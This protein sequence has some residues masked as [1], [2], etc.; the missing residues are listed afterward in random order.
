MEMSAAISLSLLSLGHKRKVKCYNGYFVNGYVFH[1]KEYGHGRKTYN[2]DVF[3]NRSTC[4]EFEV[5]YYGKLQEVVHYKISQVYRRKYSRYVIK[6]SLVIY[7]PTS[8]P[9][10]YIRQLSF[11]R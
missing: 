3:V 7:F 1:T 4:S 5:D 10:E 11:C 6:L 8:S 2:N 9:T